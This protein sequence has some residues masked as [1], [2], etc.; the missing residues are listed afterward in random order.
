MPLCLLEDDEEN[1]IMKLLSVESGSATPTDENDE[2]VAGGRS[3][4]NCKDL[5]VI[6]QLSPPPVKITRQ[7]I[8]IKRKP[9]ANDAVSSLTRNKLKQFLYEKQLN[10]KT[11][12]ADSDLTLLSSGCASNNSL[13]KSN[14]HFKRKT[15]VSLEEVCLRL[16]CI[17]SEQ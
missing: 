16:V 12:H 9:L 1:E 3:L 13:N 14:Y 10:Q 7:V 15:P 5:I 2:L 4:L 17:E 6:E 8:P 11:S